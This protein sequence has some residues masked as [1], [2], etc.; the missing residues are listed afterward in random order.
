MKEYFPILDPVHKST[1]GVTLLLIMLCWV[2]PN[3]VQSETD[4]TDTSKRKGKGY[5]V[6][7]L[8][9]TAVV[10][11]EP[12]DQIL[13]GSSIKK[14][15]FFTDLRHMENQ[16]ITHRWE[17][18]GKVISKFDFKVKGPRW[19]VYSSKV[20]SADMLGKWTVVV[21]DNKGWPLKAAVFQYVKKGAGI[22][23]LDVILPLEA[24]H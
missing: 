22:Q 11:R 18:K 4:P 17:H 21:A 2:Q 12:I 19:R 1:L 3:S 15:Y 6:R 16:T 9:T 13:V 24:A 5:V 14:V 7:A 20:L 10:D 23:N 8:F